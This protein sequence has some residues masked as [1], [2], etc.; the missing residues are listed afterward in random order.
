M[1]RLDEA[2]EA[3]GSMYAV[4][5]AQQNRRIR[6]LASAAD[7]DWGGEETL[8]QK[9]IRAVRSTRGVSSVLV[10]MRRE[11]YVEDVLEELRRPVQQKDRTKSWE[12]LQKS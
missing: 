3:V 4:K 6:R 7:A 10:G 8:S 1:A 2:F 11:R 12:I 9:A 5:V